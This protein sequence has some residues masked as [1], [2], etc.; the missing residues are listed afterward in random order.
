[1]LLDVNVNVKHRV[2]KGEDCRSQNESIEEN[3]KQ[4]NYRSVDLPQFRIK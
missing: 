3:R 1:M 2:A 4:A